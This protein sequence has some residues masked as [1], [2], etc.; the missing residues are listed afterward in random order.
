M[1]VESEAERQLEGNAVTHVGNDSSLGHRGEM[2]GIWLARYTSLEPQKW[3]LSLLLSSRHHVKADEINGF[4][5]K[6]LLPL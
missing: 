5:Q 2:E 4:K 3:D 6:P 1:E